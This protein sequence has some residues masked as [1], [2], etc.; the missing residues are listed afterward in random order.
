MLYLFFILFI[1]YQFYHNRTPKSGILFTDICPGDFFN[2]HNFLKSCLTTIICKQKLNQNINW[3]DGKR[4]RGRHS[5]KKSSFYMH[6]RKQRIKSLKMVVETSDKNQYS[7]C[8]IL[9]LLHIYI[10]KK[11]KKKILAQLK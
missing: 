3:S 1:F 4:G 9:N 5:K 6:N 10:Y 11:L 8:Y 2:K 7:Y